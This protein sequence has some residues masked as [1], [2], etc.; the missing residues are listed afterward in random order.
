MNMT[1]IFIANGSRMAYQPSPIPLKIE[2]HDRLDGP[3]TAS[4][5]VRPLALAQGAY[6]TI[7][8]VWPLVSPGTFQMVT[9][10]KV[11]VWLVKTAGVLIA[12]IGGVLTLAGW[13]RRITDEIRLLAVGSALGLAAI[14]IYY[15]ARRRISPIYLLDA[16]LELAISALWFVMPRR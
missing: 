1:I 5:T 8:G 10:P 4:D 13:R 2:A 15:A 11:D 3:E 7:T 14:D 16:A 9:G 6:F 12:V